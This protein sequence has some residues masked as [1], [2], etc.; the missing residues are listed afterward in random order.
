MGSKATYVII[1][2]LIVITFVA[3]VAAVYFYMLYRQTLTPSPPSPPTPSPTPTPSPATPSPPTPLATIRPEE[4]KPTLVLSTDVGFVATTKLN[5]SI[6]IDNILLA[7]EKLK[8]TS[9]GS[10]IEYKKAEK[11]IEVKLI[12]GP[13]PLGLPA[14][15][16]D[17]IVRTFEDGTL[18]LYGVKHFDYKID[19]TYMLWIFNFDPPWRNH[20]IDFLTSAGV[21]TTDDKDF[22]ENPHSWFQYFIRSGTY[23]LMFLSGSPEWGRVKPEQYTVKMFFQKKP[24]TLFLNDL[25]LLRKLNGEDLFNTPYHNVNFAEKLLG[26]EA[27]II[28]GESSWARTFIVSDVP[29]TVETDLE[30]QSRL[31]MITVKDITDFLSS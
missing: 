22:L 27:L 18:F 10:L 15:F 3:A 12:I 6:N 5:H 9:I 21:I 4:R 1:A 31:Q 17:Y 26:N 24:A 14:Y 20:L 13:G 7:A 19:S 23:Y 11:F 28:I 8:T 2:I 25:Y 29:F 16:F 30:Y